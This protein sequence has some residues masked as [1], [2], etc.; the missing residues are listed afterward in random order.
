MV[1]GHVG[2]VVVLTRISTN[3]SAAVRRGAIATALIC[4]TDDGGGRLHVFSVIMV[5]RRRFFG[6]TRCGRV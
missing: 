4:H 6:R 2:D 3:L 5:R 1:S